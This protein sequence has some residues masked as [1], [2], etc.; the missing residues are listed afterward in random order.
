[1]HSHGGGRRYDGLVFT[2]FELATHRRLNAAPPIGLLLTSHKN[3]SDRDTMLPFSNI[4]PRTRITP[5]KNETNL[6]CKF[7]IKIIAN[8]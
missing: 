2:G 3:H 4:P 8:T 7:T 1:M 5:K 6:G